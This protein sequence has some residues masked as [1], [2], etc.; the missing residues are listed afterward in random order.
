MR[1]TLRATIF[2]F[3]TQAMAGTVLSAGERGIQTL[4]P[5]HCDTFFG[6]RE[7]IYLNGPWRYKQVE[8]K[9]TYELGEEEAKH[10]YYD[11]DLDDSAWDEI[12]VP[13]GIEIPYKSD[14]EPSPA[15][16]RRRFA[17]SGK[18]EG[19]A[20]RLY[21]EGISWKPIVWVNGTEVGRPVNLAPGYVSE[22]H[23]I[24]ITKAVR[25][26][27]ENQVTVR[28]IRKPAV[29]RA[30]SSGLY[31]P[32]RV[33]I[34]PPIYATRVFVTPSLP[35]TAEI[36]CSVFNSHAD[37]R[38]VHLDCEISPWRG[39]EE[40]HKR[41]KGKGR[42]TTLRL[43]RRKLPPGE[44][45]L[46]FKVTVNKP[47][48]WDIYNPFLYSC[49]LY[50][51][52]ELIGCERFG[53]REITV[54]GRDFRLNGHKIYLPGISVVEGHLQRLFAVPR[55]N[56]L[57]EF[58]HRGF[59]R[60]YLTLLR[61]HNCLALYKMF[62]IP[63]DIWNDICD[64]LGLLQL[65]T[66]G[67]LAFTELSDDAKRMIVKEGH[68]IPD[69][70]TQGFPA[71]KAKTGKVASM[72]PEVVDPEGVLA[73]VEKAVKRNVGAA[74]NH[75]SIIAYAPECESGRK[76]G[77]TPLFPKYRGIL[78]RHD[79][80]R[81]FSSNQTYPMRGRTLQGEWVQ[82]NPPFDFLNYAGGTLGGTACDIAHYT[83][84]PM[85]IKWTEYNWG[86]KWYPEPK[87]IVASESLFYRG[88][89]SD[90][91]FWQRYQNTFRPILKD[92]KVD[93]KKYAELLGT[94]NLI[95]WWPDR[96]NVKLAGVHDFLDRGKLHAAM[97]ERSK[98]MIEQA[99]IHDHLVQGFGSVCGPLFRYNYSDDPDVGV[100]ALDPDALQPG[101]P[102]GEAFREACNPLFVCVPLYNRGGTHLLAGSNLETEVY[103]FNNLF[104]D[105]AGLQLT[106]EILNPSGKAVES[107]V[108][109]IGTLP[110][111]GKTSRGFIWDIPAGLATGDY[112]L[113]ARLE[114]KS[115]VLS[116]NFYH[117]YILGKEEQIA[118]I[119]STAHPGKQANAP[120]NGEEV[121]VY[122]SKDESVNADF[123][124]AAQRMGLECRD[125]KDLNELGDSRLL[126]I[127]P[128]ALDEENAPQ[129]AKLA[130]WIKKGGKL[131]CLEQTYEGKVP[132]LPDLEWKRLAVRL[133]LPIPAVGIDA[134]LVEDDHPVFVGIDKKRYW[135]T[136]N[137]PHGEVYRSL[138]MPLGVD[139]IAAGG[140]LCRAGR[141]M[142]FGMLIAE[143]DVGDGYCMFSQVEALR[144]RKYGDA[145]AFKYLYNLL[146]YF[147]YGQP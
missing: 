105:A 122:A 53:L 60:K 4:D 94:P 61:E 112:E 14:E 135:S 79:R 75:P 3:V 92:G 37:A 113:R 77:I 83:L 55:W 35:D 71:K 54:R 66:P 36:T 146:R 40:Y 126:I 33:E 141:P 131:L 51:D 127:G 6:K 67:V 12:Q 145:V 143:R 101:D 69:F 23:R 47:V 52:E 96:K 86:S 44:T 39:D 137:S 139:V 50:A 84:F 21:L 1:N 144:G 17:L 98:R 111:G 72:L 28:I 129:A 125:L 115:Q 106:V 110:A 10:R 58:N 31:A 123:A 24:D 43:G 11:K 90:T 57:F 124:L 120:T 64:E 136:W 89:R 99:R 5:R 46:S 32:V 16:Y 121:A 130:D 119:I 104:E 76:A 103:C 15:Y 85:V 73:Y 95:G 117:L 147:L 56:D 41:V 93:K 134:D 116:C 20:V 59:L 42:K 87:P 78:R 88:V 25:F 118:E 97:A 29:H 9:P 138:I 34:L 91:R 108:M 19:R 114:R 74:Y 26:G 142:V 133:A 30:I 132:W 13:K 18:H 140:Q 38:D 62:W 27:R 81:L 8:E 49:K 82:I 63:S 65:P 102:I 70:W 100:K 48:L 80:T 107:A 2:V 22:R 68:D 7:R 109:D 45:H 128:G